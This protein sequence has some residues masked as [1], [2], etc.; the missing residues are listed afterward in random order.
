MSGICAKNVHPLCALVAYAIVTALVFGGLLS[1]GFT[2][3]SAVAVP[4]CMPGTTSTLYPSAPR[5]SAPSGKVPFCSKDA[6]ANSV[7]V[8]FQAYG[9]LGVSD[10]VNDMFTS[11]S[12]ITTKSYCFKKSNQTCPNWESDGLTTL[13]AKYG[14]GQFQWSDAAKISKVFKQGVSLVDYNNWPVKLGPANVPEGVD[15]SKTYYLRDFALT[16]FSIAD[17]TSSPPKKL[18]APAAPNADIPVTLQQ[19]AFC[20]SQTNALTPSDPN[21]ESNVNED[22]TFKTGSCGYCLT[23]P[24]MTGWVAVPGLC[25]ATIFLLLVL[26]I[27]MLIP[28]LRKRE[29]FRILFIALSVICLIFLIAAVGAGGTMFIETAK[30]YSL[31]DFSQAQFMPSPV[32]KAFDGFTPS[33]GGAQLQLSSGSGKYM[34][35][36]KMTQNGQAVAYMNPFLVPNIGAAQLVAAIVLLFVFLIVFAIKTDWAA[37]TSSGDTAVAMVSPH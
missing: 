9:Y 32:D 3:F 10:G 5:Y 37:V 16:G 20:P 6:L 29:F 33:A 36:R 24:L 28:A 14:G 22:G 11:S 21:Q 30:C 13:T 2:M 34:I 35:D 27:M 1:S 26:E 23:Q 8:R 4:E 18:T 25:G 12:T 31:T 7:K 15:A 17:D 19:F